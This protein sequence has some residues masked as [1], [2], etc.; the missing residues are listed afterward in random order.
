MK[1]AC[2]LSAVKRGWTNRCRIRLEILSKGTAGE[3]WGP[4]TVARLKPS[5][6]LSHLASYAGLPAAACK[7]V[8]SGSLLGL[9]GLTSSPTTVVALGLSSRKN[10]RRF[11]PRRLAH[12][13]PRSRSIS[14]WSWYRSPYPLRCDLYQHIRASGQDHARPH[15]QYFPPTALCSEHGLLQAYHY[16][17][18]L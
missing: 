14:P 5:H 8:N 12:R 4:V 18:G 16:S 13:R 9:F 11:A 1:L 15:P 10:S 2:S 3:L 7:S 6:C 17:F